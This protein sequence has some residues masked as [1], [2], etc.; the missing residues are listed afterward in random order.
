MLWHS[1]RASTRDV[2]SGRR[3]DEDLSQAI[4]RVGA[5][6]DLRAGWLNDKAAQ[7]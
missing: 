5:R 4:G 1:L 7:F 2:D 3:F 6:H